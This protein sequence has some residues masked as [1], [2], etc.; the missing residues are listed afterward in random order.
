MARLAGDMREVHEPADAELVRAASGGDHAAFAVLIARYQRAVHAVAY[1]TLRD[2]SA[3]DDIAQD[4]FIAAWR[5]LRELRDGSRFAAWLCAITRNI[6]RD[7][8]RKLR[9]HVP[10]EP[11]LVDPDSPLEALT[12]AE[13]AQLVTDALALVPEDSREPLVLFYYE[14]RSA[15]DVARL[16]GISEDTA[17]KR[18]SRARRQLARGYARALERGLSRQQPRRGLVASV[19]AA[20]ALAEPAHV[21]AATRITKGSSVPKLSITTLALSSLGAG[22][23][24]VVAAIGGTVDGADASPRTRSSASTRPAAVATPRSP[25]STARAA[26]GP[27]NRTSSTTGRPAMAVA[28]DPAC[29]ALGAHLAA[30]TTAAVDAAA[31]GAGACDDAAATLAASTLAGFLADECRNLGMTP[32]YR[33]CVLAAPDMATV[34]ACHAGD[35]APTSSTASSQDADG[36]TCQVAAAHLASLLDPSDDHPGVPVAVQRALGIDASQLAG[37]CDRD[38]WPAETRRCV[39]EAA[40]AFELYDCL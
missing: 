34:M 4:A 39:V 32:A 6:A 12:E 30:L 2:T 15:R 13:S 40:S 35:A 37:S 25:T 28:P 22:T 1:A 11:G 21:E 26:V 17:F 9:C 5:R 20:I 10:L 24:V 31:S 8:R 7:A 14:Q 29:D 23:L 19:L 3:S 18:L 33:A 38:R 27:T 36:V 16:L